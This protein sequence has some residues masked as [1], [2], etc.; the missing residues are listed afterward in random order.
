MKVDR[1]Q[2]NLS[3]KEEEIKNL[4][5]TTGGSRL[6]SVG[7]STGAN[8]SFS[9]IHDIS[10]DEKAIEAQQCLLTPGKLALPPLPLPASGLAKV[11]GP[12]A[13]ST[14]NKPGLGSI[15]EELLNLQEFSEKEC[16][17]S[18]LCEKKESQ[19]SV[20]LDR[21]LDNI[22]AAVKAQGET[23]NK[24]ELLAAIGREVF[25]V[26]Q[27]LEDFLKDLPSLEDH[28]NLREKRDQLEA[29]LNEANSLIEHLK[30]KSENNNKEVEEEVRSSL[31]Q[32]HAASPDP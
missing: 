32:A 13:S 18:P 23:K 22:S 28:N 16:L 2:Q 30:L 12:S 11:R 25:S 31:Q 3:M 17:A 19:L 20:A 29:E 26:K 7:S 4:T 8:H 6:G 9:T 15:A 24:K 27:V 21:M 5:E 1:L 14:P 10:V